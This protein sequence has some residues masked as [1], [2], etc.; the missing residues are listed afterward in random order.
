MTLR[1]GEIVFDPSGRSMPAWENAP[2]AYWKLP[3]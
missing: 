1:A 2:E 3:W